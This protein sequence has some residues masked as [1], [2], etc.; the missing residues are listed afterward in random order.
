MK[1]EERILQTAFTLFLR[2]GF[3]DVSTNEIIRKADT[4]KGGFYYCFKSREDL[5][6]RVI[7]SYIMP[8]YQEP[9]VAMQEAWETKCP[10]VSTKKLLWDAYFAPQRFIQYQKTIGMEITFRDFYFLLYEGMKKFPEVQQCFAENTRQREDCLR[11]ILERG[12]ERKEITADFDMSACVMM[13]LAMQDGILALKVLDEHIDDEEKYHYIE[14]QI[15]K[16]IAAQDRYLK[17]LHG[18]ANNAVS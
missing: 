17:Y 2:D 3:A 4:T 14:E 7:T 6:H 15:W 16:E 11:R 12:K 8:Y 18:G 10:D 13:T 5:V 9:I 1:T